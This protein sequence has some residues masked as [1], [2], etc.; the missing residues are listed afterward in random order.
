[1]NN[2]C[3]IAFSKQQIRHNVVNIPKHD[4]LFETNHLKILTDNCSGLIRTVPNVRVKGHLFCLRILL[5]FHCEYS[6][7]YS[8]RYQ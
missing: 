2:Y 8:K 7:L 5:F 3:L 6:M 4:N 1:M